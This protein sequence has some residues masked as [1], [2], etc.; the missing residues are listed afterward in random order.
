MFVFNEKP[1]SNHLRV[2]LHGKSLEQA[3]DTVKKAIEF[4]KT[5]GKLTIEVITGRGNHPNSDGRR[6]LIL[7]AFPKWLEDSAIK[8]LIQFAQKK[9]G[10]YLIG[11]NRTVQDNLIS[12]PQN[13]REFKEDIEYKFS[14]PPK[15]IS[16]KQSKY[17]SENN[18][19]MSA[20]RDKNVDI[21]YIE[22]LLNTQP[23][24]L[25]QTKKDGTTVLMLAAAINRV[26][27]MEL[28]FT[29][30]PQ[31]GLLKLKRNDGY[32]ALMA[33]VTENTLKQYIFC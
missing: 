15:A 4:A 16:I 24:L 26:D 21:K 6:G 25:K 7:K 32:T 17:S 5:N 31:N 1:K 19:L 12:S 3:K 18:A 23:G 10:A 29:K 33:A 9:V 30:R 22:E 11:L 13:S 27:I 28:I 20:L 8:P 14:G 2:D